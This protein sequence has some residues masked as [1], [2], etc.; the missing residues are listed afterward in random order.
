MSIV[1]LSSENFQEEVMNSSL[2]VLVDFYAEWCGPCKMISPI[3][4]ELAES[5]DG[6]IKVAKLDIDQSGDI[7]SSQGVMSI[8]TIIF[9][10]NGEKVEENTG[11]L[12]KGQLEELIQK[13]IAE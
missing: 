13:V 4:D 5:Y 3:I 7:A 10:K 8:P 12:D 2:P 9:F 6:K 11:A 1:K